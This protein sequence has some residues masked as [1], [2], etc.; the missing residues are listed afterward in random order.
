TEINGDK[1][2]VNN[3]GD[4]TNLDVCNGTRLTGDDATA[5]NRGNTTV[6][7]QGSTGTALA[8]NNAV[9]TQDGELDVSGGGH[10]IDIP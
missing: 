2:I 9:V 5:N 7:G 10:G 1:D 6:E 8:G 3:E 4:S